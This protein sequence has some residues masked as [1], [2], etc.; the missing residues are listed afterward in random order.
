MRRV[1]LESLLGF[2]RAILSRRYFYAQ[3]D[4]H[5]SEAKRPVSRM[6]SFMFVKLRHISKADGMFG[7]PK[8]QRR[9]A[10]ASFCLSQ[11]FFFN[12]LLIAYRKLIVWGLDILFLVY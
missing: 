9:L 11:S 2:A 3:E 7:T 8:S 4:L 1:V 10:C 12:L 5:C 6:N